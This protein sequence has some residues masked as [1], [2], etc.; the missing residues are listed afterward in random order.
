[1][2][3]LIYLGF[4]HQEFQTLKMVVG[5]F[6]GAWDAKLLLVVSSGMESCIG[7]WDYSDYSRLV[8]GFSRAG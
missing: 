6:E 3:V 5:L 8:G 4:H 2:T 7:L 1:M